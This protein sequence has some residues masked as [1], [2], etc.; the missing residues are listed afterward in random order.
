MRS[1]FSPTLVVA[2]YQPDAFL[3]IVQGADIVCLHIA[4]GMCDALEINRH[5]LAG[6][7]IGGTGHRR[8]SGAF[9]LCGMKNGSAP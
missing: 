8:L 4:Y 9:H 7:A 6:G 1:D 2:F 3:Q 5:A